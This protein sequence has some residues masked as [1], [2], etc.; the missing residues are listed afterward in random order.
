MFQQLVRMRRHTGTRTLTVL[1][2]LL[3]EFEYVKGARR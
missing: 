1:G 2:F 3:F